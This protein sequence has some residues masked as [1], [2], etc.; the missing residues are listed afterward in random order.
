MKRLSAFSIANSA[1][2]KLQVDFQ[3]GAAEHVLAAG[4]GAAVVGVA[5]LAIGWHTLTYAMLNVFP[6]IAVFAAVITVA[7][8]FL[9]KESAIN[10]RKKDAKEVVDRYYQFFIQ[11]LYVLKLPSL[12]YKSISKYM[13]ETGENIV[14]EAVT[15]WEE[16]YFENLTLDHFRKLNQAFV[17][18]LMYVN[19]AIE[20]IELTIENHEY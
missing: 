11:Q 14:N 12:G 2:T 4:L 7:T 5:G 19:E 3:L 16:N 15:K 18:H 20:E 9:T 13:D 10:K 8:G 6:P 1:R 17:R